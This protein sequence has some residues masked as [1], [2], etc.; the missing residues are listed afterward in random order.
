ML[1]NVLSRLS[2]L[3]VSTFV[4]TCISAAT[5]DVASALEI[6]VSE[7]RPVEVPLHMGSGINLTG[8]VDAT[9]KGNG[10]LAIGNLSLRLMKRH[11]DGIVYGGNGILRLDVTP[12]TSRSQQASLV[13]SG[14]LVRTGD[15]ES[16][17]KT[18]DVLVAIYS[19]NC[20]SGKFERAFSTSDYDID[21]GLNEKSKIKC[22]HQIKD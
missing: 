18:H 21:L 22:R 16:D 6:A 17:P 9:N 4:S 5:V 10:T 12:F 1:F 8:M 13:I 2:V 15:K 20:K 14:D 19:L 11:D 3:F 7:H